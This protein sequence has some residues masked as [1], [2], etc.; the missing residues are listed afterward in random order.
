MERYKNRISRKIF[1][2]E[3]NTR[4]FFDQVHGACLRSYCKKNSSARSEKDHEHIIISFSGDVIRDLHPSENLV[5]QQTADQS[6]HDR[7]NNTEVG[8]GDTFSCLFVFC[9]ASLTKTDPESTRESID[10]TEYKN[11]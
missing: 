10:K 9:T 3:E 11:K 5:S 7:K 2:T 1:K 6:Q 8:C 4:K